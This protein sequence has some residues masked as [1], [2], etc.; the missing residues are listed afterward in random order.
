MLCRRESGHNKFYN[1]LQIEHYFSVIQSVYVWQIQYYNKHRHP[2]TT[3]FDLSAYQT[4]S[5]LQLIS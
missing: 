5:D 1:T 2:A 3:V 4:A